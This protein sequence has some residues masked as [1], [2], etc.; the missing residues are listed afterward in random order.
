MSRNDDT[1]FFKKIKQRFKRTTSWN[2]YKSE[3]EN[4]TQKQQFWLYDWSF[5]QKC[6]DDLTRD[7]FDKYYMSLVEIKDFNTL[8][9]KKH[10][11]DY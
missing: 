9:D 6:D 7:S 1:N 8:I 4:T 10:F 11:F 5:I 2:K 3:D